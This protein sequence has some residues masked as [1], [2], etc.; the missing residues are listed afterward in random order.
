MTLGLREY[1]DGVTRNKTLEERPHRPGTC[2]SEEGS[3]QAAA[4]ASDMLRGGPLELGLKPPEKECCQVGAGTSKGD[5]KL[6][7]KKPSL[8]KTRCSCWDEGPLL[9]R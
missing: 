1:R 5:M 2:T 4:S 6:V 7:L 3:C 8:G 9:G